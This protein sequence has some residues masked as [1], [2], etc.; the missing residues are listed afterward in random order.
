MPEELDDAGLAEMFAR[1]HAD[2]MA[3]IPAQ[4]LTGVHVLARRRARKQ[5]ITAAVVTVLAVAVP[6]AAYAMTAGGRHDRDPARPKPSVS[7]SPSPRHSSPAPS[8]PTTNGAAAPAPNGRIPLAELTGTAIDLPAWSSDGCPS[9]H[10]TLRPVAD[11]REQGAVG[12]DTIEYGD[13]DADGAQETIALLACPLGEAARQQVVA[14]DRDD[15]GSIVV[16][17][18]VVRPGE[19]TGSIQ[20]LYG[21]K[22][23]VPTGGVGVEVSDHWACCGGIEAGSEHQWR[24]YTWNGSAFRQTDGP[25]AFT[26]IPAEYGKLSLT[27]TALTLGAPT[28]GVR[29]GSITMT[30]TN[31][32]PG[33]APGVRLDLAVHGPD[34]G[35]PE[36][37]DIEGATKDCAPAETGGGITCHYPALPAGA[38]RSY[39]FTVG[40]PAAN[41]T[42]ISAGAHLSVDFHPEQPGVRML[43]AFQSMDTSTAL[44]IKLID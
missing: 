1:Y 18:R 44:E 8:S 22:I 3:E 36:P 7:S 41:D 30:V 6:T 43:D 9:E 32:G 24:W 2:V 35:P 11:E 16:L 33:T 19:G 29:H 4:D 39:T 38:S 40:S 13:V 23:D 14:F 42:A 5:L 27:A 20:R 34:G 25:T 37:V 12:V 28:D 26:P 15:D 21:L 10:V 17:G 31:S